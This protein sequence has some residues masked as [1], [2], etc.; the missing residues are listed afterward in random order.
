MVNDKMMYKK[1]MTLVIIMMMTIIVQPIFGATIISDGE[2]QIPKQLMSHTAPYLEFA[3]T[4]Q[5]GTL[6]DFRIASISGTSRV[7]SR[8]AGDTDWDNVVEWKSVQSGGQSYIQTPLRIQPTDTDVNQI[9]LQIYT[10]DATKNSGGM[11]IRSASSDTDDYEIRLISPKPDIQFYDSDESTPDGKFILSSNNNSFHIGSRNAGDTDWQDLMNFTSI[12]DGGAI[13]TYG[14]VN[15]ASPTEMGFLSGLSSNAQSQINGIKTKTDYITITQAVNL[16]TIESD[17]NDLNANTSNWN[18][19]YGWGNH[20]DGNYLDL[21]TYPNADTDSTNDLTTT[22]S[23]IGDVSGTGSTITVNDNSHTLHWNNLT[24]VPAGFSDGTDD[25]DD[26]DADATNEIQNVISNMGLQRDGSNNFGL[27]STCSNSQVL[28]YNTTSSAWEC[29]ND[30][31]EGS[32]YSAG[33]GLILTSTTFSLNTTYLDANYV[34]QTEYPNLDTDSTDDFSG[35]WDDLTSVPAGFSDGTDNDTQLTESEVDAYA[36]NNNYLDLDTY[37]NADTDSTDD[38]SGSWNDLTSV[39]AGFSDGVDNDTQ[40]TE[41]QVDAFTDNNNY[42]DKDDYACSDT[43]ILAYN[44]TSGAWECKTSSSGG[45]T[46]VVEDTT[47][48][49]GGNLNAGYHAILNVDNVELQAP[50][51]SFAFYEDDQ[52]NG[53]GKWRFAIS[54]GIW[55]LENR[56]DNDTGYNTPVIQSQRVEDGGAITTYG[57][58]NGAS[59]TEM[60]YLSGVTSNIQT[61]LDDVDNIQGTT[62]AETSPTD[63]QIL[64]YN[65]TSTNYEPESFTHNSIEF[66]NDPTNHKLYDNSTCVIIQ[67]DTS[68]FN[69]C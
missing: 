66:E 7:Q 28:K 57:D 42:F 10:N 56:Y 31:N 32:T 36:D 63:G 58:V 8:N 68:T 43:Q 65:S 38:F 5:N 25:V 6:G 26:A 40:L 29:E 23:W 49:L 55:K 12:S 22:T 48:E 45:I 1:I 13:V 34:G 52:T 39:P 59:P 3:E 19:A 60:G 30:N 53:T 64:Q 61:Q 21:D 27:I 54:G 67:G 4:D 24:S 20:A 47:P 9:M 51:P 37:P 2:T 14:D 62:I 41:T 35:S 44:S 17:V 46:A 33:T 69:I 18:T 11:Q 15:G 16:D 50:L